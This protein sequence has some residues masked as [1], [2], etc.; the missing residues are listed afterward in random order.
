MCI[1]TRISNSLQTQDSWFIV[2]RFCW[3]KDSSGKPPCQYIY[4]LIFTYRYSLSNTVAP[5]LNNVFLFPTSFEYKD[6]L[7]QPLSCTEKVRKAEAYTNHK[8][9]VAGQIDL[10]IDEGKKGC[11]YVTIGNCDIE[12]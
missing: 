7:E 5:Y 3:K 2:T 12:Y 9:L 8:Q 6:I 1:S 10:P 11:Y 4:L